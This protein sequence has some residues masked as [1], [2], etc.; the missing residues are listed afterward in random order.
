MAGVP[1]VVSKVQ[2]TIDVIT[3]TGVG[4]LVN[5]TQAEVCGAVNALFRN[6]VKYLEMRQK[7]IYE[8]RAVY[9]WSAEEETLRELVS[10]V[11]ANRTRHYA[12][13]KSK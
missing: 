12:S 8:S 9:N 11:L 1:T 10:S 4:V 3:R 13:S 6:K 7:A 5:F 2:G